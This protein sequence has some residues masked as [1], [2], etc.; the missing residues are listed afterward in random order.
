MAKSLTRE[1]VHV[2]VGALTTDDEIVTEVALTVAG[3]KPIWSAQVGYAYNSILA[4]PG[5]FPELE[6]LHQ[7]SL[8]LHQPR[9][10]VLA[11]N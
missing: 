11:N 1:L 10:R 2:L 9:L 4:P 5:R 7:A 6:Q 8:L 3:G